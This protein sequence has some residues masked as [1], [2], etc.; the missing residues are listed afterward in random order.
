MRGLL[1]AGAIVLAMAGTCR[2]SGYQEFNFG[3]AALNR[4]DAAETVKRLTSALAT[5]D[6]A[7]SF[8]AVAYLDRGKA[9]LTSGNTDAAIA[10]F[11]AALN[12]R[13]NYIDAYIERAVAYR[14]KRQY[15]LA[16]ADLTGAIRLRP[17][18][19]R[20]YLQRMSIYA[21]LQRYDDELADCNA[22]LGYWPGDPTLF[23]RRGLVYRGMGKYALAIAESSGAIAIDPE[24]A[25][26]YTSRGRARELGDDL[27]DAMDDFDKAISLDHDDADAQMDKGFIEWHAARFDKA[28]TAFRRV[29]ELAP[30]SVWGYLGDEMVH[31]RLGDKPRRDFD[32]KAGSLDL[33]AWP[34]PM[35]AL[36]L[37]KL[38]P[39]QLIQAAAHGEGRD[40][41]DQNCQARLFLAEWYSGR[42]DSISARKSL[43]QAATTCPL[44]MVELSIAKSELARMPAPD[45]GS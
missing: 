32:D 24:F 29:V 45:G 15:D 16:I 8:K 35:V 4:D 42:K 2:A 11:S 43:Q 31:A 21:A 22:L 17:R 20:A 33:A 36:F 39:D 40:P 44:D 37:G 30:A 23:V 19:P 10:D 34:G 13:P 27:D 3:I 38:T 41:L 14:T 28:E 18:H 7:P 25:Y 9:Y 6:L 5:P 26:A 12:V 1:L